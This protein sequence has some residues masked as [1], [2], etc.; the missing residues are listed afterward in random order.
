MDNQFAD[1]GAIAS[2]SGPAKKL[3][4]DGFRVLHRSVAQPYFPL[5]AHAKF[6]PEQIKA[7]QMALASLPDKPGGSEILQRIGIAA[8]DTGA[9]ERMKGL[10]DWL[11]K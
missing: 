8:F 7:I 5:V 1:V 9:E 6:K 11:E 4:K 3:D 2:Y 10:L